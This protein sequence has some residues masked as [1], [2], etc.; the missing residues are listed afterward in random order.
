[1]YL[2]KNYGLKDWVAFAEVFGMPLR[3]GKYAPGASRE[4]KDAL[5]AAIRSLGSDAAGVISKSTEIEFVEAVQ[6]GGTQILYE[7]LANFCDKQVSK[8]IPANGTT[9]GTR[10]S[11]GNEDDKDRVRHDLIRTTARPCQG[12]SVSGHPPLV[13]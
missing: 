9:E 6:K 12:R 10:A 8:A 13:G 4:D 11:W 3:R 7:V 1:M 2:F 5:G